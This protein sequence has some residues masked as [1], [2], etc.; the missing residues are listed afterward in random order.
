MDMM[1]R[2]RHSLRGGSRG[3][4]ATQEGTWCT[5]PHRD[6]VQAFEEKFN[7]FL[8]MDVRPTRVRELRS[9]TKDVRGLG[10]R[11]TLV[12]SRR[13]EYTS[14]WYVREP[15]R[16]AGLAGFKAFGK[17]GGADTYTFELIAAGRAEDTSDVGPL[18]T[19]AEGRTGLG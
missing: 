15:R 14:A 5:A 4:R 16:F 18:S 13:H 1:S 11:C 8:M 6:N 7:A 9:R 3:S 17:E 19:D 2:N 12:Q 10:E